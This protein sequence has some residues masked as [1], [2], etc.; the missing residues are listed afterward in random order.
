[1]TIPDSD[2][3][4]LGLGQHSHS[5]SGSG[6]RRARFGRRRHGRRR[7]GARGDAGAASKDPAFFKHTCVSQWRRALPLHSWRVF[8]GP[9]WS[10]PVLCLSATTQTTPA[11]RRVAF[12]AGLEPSCSFRTVE[13]GVP[14]PAPH[15]PQRYRAGLRASQQCPRR[16]SDT[17]K[18]SRRDMQPP[19]RCTRHKRPGAARAPPP[20]AHGRG[21][22]RR[23]RPRRRRRPRAPGR[24]AFTIRW[25]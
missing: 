10:Q 12:F 22:R 8:E 16:R 25:R 13:D 19:Q 11:R 23:A 1:M 15:G 7:A 4:K 21:V 20:A 14:K 2:H 6:R 5:D 24:S 18:C 17:K 9:A 3:F